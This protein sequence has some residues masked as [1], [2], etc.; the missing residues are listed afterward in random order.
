MFATVPVSLRSLSSRFPP[1]ISKPLAFEKATKASQSS[2]L[3][4]NLAV[5]FLRRKELVVEGA[6]RILDFLHEILQPYA[7]AKRQNNV[8]AQGLGCRKFSDEL[9]LAIDNRVAHMSR[10]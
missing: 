10:Q 8:E 5:N 4:P 7:I 9:R 1:M 2:W 6:C 3:G